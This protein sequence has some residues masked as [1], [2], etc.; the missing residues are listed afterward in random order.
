MVLVSK[1]VEFLNGHFLD[2]SAGPFE[3]EQQFTTDRRRHITANQHFV[4]HLA[5]IDSFHDRADT[6]NHFFLRRTL[7]VVR[8]MIYHIF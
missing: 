5:G 8:F 2:G 6:E 7:G 3:F 1:L 4:Q